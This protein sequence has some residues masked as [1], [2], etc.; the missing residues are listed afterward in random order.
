MSSGHSI[1][2]IDTDDCS[3]APTIEHVKPLFLMY[4]CFLNLSAIEKDWNYIW[5][6]YS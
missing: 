2:E 3:K 5:A 6:E 1:T 4:R